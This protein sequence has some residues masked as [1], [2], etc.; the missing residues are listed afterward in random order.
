MRARGWLDEARVATPSTGSNT[1][2]LRPLHRRDLPG[3]LA[4]EVG[5]YLIEFRVPE[6]WDAAIDQP[7]VL[8]HRFENNRSFLMAGTNGQLSLGVGDSFR[9]RLDL[10]LARGVRVDV[11]AIDAKKR[12]ATISV[13]FTARDRPP[14]LP[15]PPEL[16]AGTLLGGITVDGG[17]YAIVGGKLV[18]VPPRGPARDLLAA[19]VDYL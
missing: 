17:G 15:W 12:T 8:V 10:I 11:D 7:R 3:D 5:P 16:V 1:I 13:R 6:K 14:V 4:I 9:S 2:V 19:L 18:K